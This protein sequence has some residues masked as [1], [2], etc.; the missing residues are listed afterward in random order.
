MHALGAIDEA[1]PP[2]SI[3]KL[4]RGN[5]VVVCVKAP[6][7]A[8]STLA[9]TLMNEF[10]VL[11]LASNAP[12]STLVAYFVR[13]CPRL[14]FCLLEDFAA[15][16]AAERAAIPSVQP[17]E[18]YLRSDPSGLR[19]LNTG[20]VDPS[21][22][23]LIMQ[24]AGS[25]SHPKLVPFSLRRLVETGLTITSWTQ[26]SVDDI[27]VSMMPLHHIDGISSNLIAPI[28][29]GSHTQMAHT[30]W[31]DTAGWHVPFESNGI[32]LTWA[33]ATSGLWLQMIR[34]CL[35]VCGVHGMRFIRSGGAYLPLAV[36]ERLAA[37][38]SHTCVLTGYSMLVREVALPPWMA[39]VWHAFHLLFV[40]VNRRNACPSL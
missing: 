15:T 2:T 17:P 18:S 6:D 12:I 29:A 39:Y 5:C 30:I 1:L 19:T 26:L 9:L 34:S 20:P 22:L 28:V 14:I 37:A 21:R 13:T 16:I 24:T 25:C 3:R 31:H 33:L 38:Y 27:G 7:A 4:E 10:A 32:R 8:A 23:V 35:R 40:V 11:L 36:A